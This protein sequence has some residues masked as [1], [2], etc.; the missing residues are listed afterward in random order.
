MYAENRSNIWREKEESKKEGKENHDSAH[1][2]L[3]ESRNLN[4][5]LKKNPEVRSDY[6]GH[7]QSISVFI[8][9]FW[10][11][12]LSVTNLKCALY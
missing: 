4:L 12:L 8:H 3:T 7:I 10:A 6:I 9:A 5:L 11:G 1:T 2:W